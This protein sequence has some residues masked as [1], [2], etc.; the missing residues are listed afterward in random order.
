VEGVKGVET[1]RKEGRERGRGQGGRRRQTL[2]ER[3]D[4]VASML[5]GVVKDSFQSEEKEKIFRG[6][7]MGMARRRGRKAGRRGRKGGEESEV[8]RMVMKEKGEAGNGLDVCSISSSSSS[9]TTT[10]YLPSSTTTPSTS[11]SLPPLLLPFPAYH[12]SLDHVHNPTPEYYSLRITLQ[13]L[14]YHV[15][16]HRGH[17]F[18]LVFSSLLPAANLKSPPPPAV[19]FLHRKV[20]V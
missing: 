19:P 15:H 18:Q 2:K 11:S 3:R 20:D 9:V 7:V 6:R 10:F 14:F 12:P 1:R 17:P 5:E 4:R 16:Q 13:A 8:E